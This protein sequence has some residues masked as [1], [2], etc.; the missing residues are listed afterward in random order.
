MQAIHIGFELKKNFM[1]QSVSIDEVTCNFKTCVCS[2]NL[3]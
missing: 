3:I 1:K 2:A